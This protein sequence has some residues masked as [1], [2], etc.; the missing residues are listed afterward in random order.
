LIF[1]TVGT[2]LPFDRLIES[3]DAWALAKRR[4][5]VFAQIG[6]GAHYSPKACKSAP[7]LSQSE[8]Q[9]KFRQASAIVSHAGIGTIL[10]A[11]ELGKP[12]VVLPRLAQFGEHRNDHQLATAQKFTDMNLVKVA[13][14]PQEL[15][16]ALDE[17]ESL[18]TGQ[19][20]SHHASPQL[21][22]FLKNFI[23]L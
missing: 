22:S 2:Q 23:S 6:A 19:T 16:R 4:S 10:S 15:A 5:D 14:S 9:D 1:V 18:H 8:F 11:L 20:I 17:I 12:I 13:N 7:S 3:V 21:L